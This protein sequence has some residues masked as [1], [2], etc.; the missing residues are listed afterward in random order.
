MKQ[1]TF[2]TITLVFSLSLVILCGELAIRLYHYVS[3][4]P[5]M[6]RYIMLDDTLGWRPTENLLFRGE[7]QDAV[8]QH[9]Q[10]DIQTNKDGFRIF[11]DIQENKKKK[12]LFI[13][14]SFTHA[15]E[16]SNDKAY[17]SVLQDALP[18]EVFAFGV[19]GYGTL[20]EFM[21]LDRW[22]EKINPSLV[23]LQYT[24]NDFINNHY[25]LER[26]SYYNNNSMMRPYLTKYGTL[27]YAFPKP[28]PHFHEFSNRYSQFVHFL[29]RR[30]DFLQST[31]TITVEDV[32]SKEGAAFPPLQ[33]SIGITENILKK[34]QAR[35]PSGTTTAV[36]AVD[37]TQPYYDIFKSITNNRHIDFLDGVPQ[38]IH[39]A[40]RHGIVV[41]A[42]DKAHWNERGHRIA[43]EVLQPHISKLLLGGN[44]QGHNAK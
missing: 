24:S 3:R 31:W 5:Y 44:H 19:C 6:F 43:A 10:L 32:I 28:W 9:Y 38:A 17:Y 35:L 11:G 16:V 25:D 12:V 36:F 21:I 40:E 1:L 37:D 26:R 29:L 8:G 18:I 33:E 30:I 42:A 23:I 2:G 39:E 41:M 4:G 13:G 27:I 34:I 15:I 20:Q 7:T 14:D 22:I